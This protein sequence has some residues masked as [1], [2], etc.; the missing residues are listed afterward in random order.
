M[1]RRASHSVP[2]AAFVLALT[3]CV[4]AASASDSAVTR[5]EPRFEPT[6]RFSDRPFD[7]E[8]RT[9]FGTA[10]GLF[11]AAFEY[12]LTEQ[13]TI[14]VGA[15]VNPWGFIWDAHTRFRVFETE[16]FNQAD[17]LSL[18]VSFS[19]GPYGSLDPFGGLHDRP[20]IDPVG[21]S[22]IQGELGWERRFRSGW[23]LRPSF[24]LA[25][26]LNSPDWQCRAGGTVV[27]CGNRTFPRSTLPVVTLAVGYAFGGS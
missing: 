9:G 10:V 17:A 3:Q 14:G 21:V 27:P 8:L 2:A 22:W 20:E 4:F 19:R 26:Q 24:G 25:T 12:T 15:G 13:F 6:P 18:E 11:G 23:S 5:P 1:A 7:A 16:R